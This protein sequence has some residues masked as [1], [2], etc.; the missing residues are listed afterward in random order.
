MELDTASQVWNRANEYPL[1]PDSGLEAGDRALRDLCPAHNA[2]QNGGLGHCLDIFDS[3]QLDRAEQGYRHFGLDEAANALQ[4]ARAS[5]GDEEDLEQLDN[6][7]YSLDREL[8]GI[9]RAR[10]EASP[11]E[12]S[13][14]AR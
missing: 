7:F 10:F 2:I 5:V 1:H 12:F 13:P 11:E 8:L 14:L 4:V 3:E 9:F 6:L